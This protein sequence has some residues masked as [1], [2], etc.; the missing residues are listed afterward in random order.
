MGKIIPRPAKEIV[1]ILE[2]FG[3]KFVSRGRHDK[4]RNE[5]KGISVPVPVSHGVISRGV[6]QSLIRQTGIPREEFEV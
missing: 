4:Y 1:K 2:K 3:F 5:E 6:I